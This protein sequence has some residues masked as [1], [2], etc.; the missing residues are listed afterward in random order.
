MCDDEREKIYQALKTFKGEHDEHVKELNDAIEL[1][2]RRYDEL[3]KE[4]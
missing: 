1:T 3:L 4:V 2:E